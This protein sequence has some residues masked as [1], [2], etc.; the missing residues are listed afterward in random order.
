LQNECHCNPTGI[1]AGE[2]TLAAAGLQTSVYRGS[3]ECG[4]GHLPENRG[5]VLA[6]DKANPKSRRYHDT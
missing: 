2:E 1:G 3:P 5:G 4:F 6:A